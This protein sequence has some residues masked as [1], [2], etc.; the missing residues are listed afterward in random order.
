MQRALSHHATDTDALG[1]AELV[2]L[3]QQGN[4]SAFR[5]IMRRHNRR[6]LRVARSILRDDSEAEDEAQEAY[7]RAFMGMAAFSGAARLSTW[8]TCIALNEALGRLRRRRRRPSVELKTLDAVQERDR[9]HIIPF[10]L[11][12]TATDPERTAAQRETLGLLEQAIDDL[13]EPFRVVFVLRDVEE[14]S[15]EETA[16]HL[17]LRPETVK[18]RLFRAR[19]LLRRALDERLAST[20]RDA[21]PFAGARCA[22][23]ADAVLRRLGLPASPPSGDRERGS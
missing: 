17:G 20:L 22:R 18:T 5:A 21:F 15:I 10:P 2:C 8:L 16:A 9:A 23:I 4:A 14:L 7:V 12:I 11:M 3:A 19:R 6:L 13:P 1:D